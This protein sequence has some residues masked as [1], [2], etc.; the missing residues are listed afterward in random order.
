MPMITPQQLLQQ[1]Q[2]QS[3]SRDCM[4]VAIDGFAGAGKS[5]LAKWLAEHLEACQIM[6][7]DDFYQP[8][9]NK[10]WV[11]LSEEAALQAY[12]PTQ[13]LAQQLLQPLQQGQSI[14]WQAR[15]WLTKKLSPEKKIVPR[16]VILVDGVFSS[17]KDFRPWVDLRILVSTLPSTCRRRVLARPQPNTDWF[18]HWQ[19]TETWFHN[20]N[21]T[22][23]C[24]DYVTTGSVPQDVKLDMD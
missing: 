14:T 10:Q 23:L 18:A 16:G 4:V 8:L 5:T 21:K 19:R 15:D 1:L 17:H 20:H 6:S 11:Q 22:G 12:L 9:A 24:V 13:T 7:L 2:Q 3:Q